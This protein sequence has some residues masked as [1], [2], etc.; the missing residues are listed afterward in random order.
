[1]LKAIVERLNAGDMDAAEALFSE[2][3]V[4]HDPNA[5][6]WP[7]GREG[8]RTMLSAFH[9]IRVEPLDMIEEGDR[10]CVRWAFSGVRDR[11][12]ITASCVAIYRFANNMIA[13]DWGVTVRAPWP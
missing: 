9:G 7:R 12:P 11:V 6:D 10:V 2:D 13:E 1:L 4:L 3:F 5:P 8:V